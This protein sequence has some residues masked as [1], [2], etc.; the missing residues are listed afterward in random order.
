MALVVKNMLANTGDARDADSIP[1]SERPGGGHGSPLQ[2]P[3]LGNPMDRGAWGATVHG[4]AKTW[5]WLSSSAHAHS[6]T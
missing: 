3:C 1:G 4:V 5:T 2:C 6:E